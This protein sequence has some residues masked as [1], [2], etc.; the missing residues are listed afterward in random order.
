MSDHA[1]HTGCQCQGVPMTTPT[2][3][4]AVGEKLP[5]MEPF[6]LDLTKPSKTVSTPLW[7]PSLSGVLAA[8]LPLHPL[9]G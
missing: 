6:S 7:Y 8:G 4:Q 5:Q 3:T 2:I 9:T 1:V